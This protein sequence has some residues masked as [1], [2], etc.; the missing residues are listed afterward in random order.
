M[1]WVNTAWSMSM[2]PK[3]SMPSGVPISSNAPG[4]VHPIGEAAEADTTFDSSDLSRLLSGGATPDNAV[5]GEDGDGDLSGGP[6]TGGGDD[7]PEGSPTY[8]G[9]GSTET[10]ARA[11]TLSRRRA[12][13][14]R[15]TS[16]PTATLT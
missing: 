16:M 13:W 1:M 7:A 15:S 5:G 8:G 3:R 6:Q 4:V 11:V 2:P 9:G 10:A 12:G 14:A